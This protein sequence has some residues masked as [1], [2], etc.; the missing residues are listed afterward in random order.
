[1]EMKRSGHGR[2]YVDKDGGLKH[3]YQEPAPMSAK[4]I[5]FVLDCFYNA[6]PDFN[7]SQQ[8]DREMATHDPK[9][10]LICKCGVLVYAIPNYTLLDEC[11]GCEAPFPENLD[12]EEMERRMSG[13]LLLAVKDT[14]GQLE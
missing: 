1:M 8:E 10:G 5:D 11:P 3:E 7:K 14:I 4:L 12:M 2:I 13:E 9:I 6:N